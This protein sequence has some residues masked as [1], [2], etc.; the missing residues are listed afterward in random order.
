MKFLELGVPYITWGTQLL[1]MGQEDPGRYI[2]IL[3][4]PFAAWEPW[5]IPTNRYDMHK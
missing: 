4:L 1:L 3:L 5:P 2:N